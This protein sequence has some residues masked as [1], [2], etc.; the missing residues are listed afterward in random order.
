MLAG[1]THVF[2]SLSEP[3]E[4]GVSGVFEPKPVGDTLGLVF[5]VFQNLWPSPDHFSKSYPQVMVI[6][7]GVEW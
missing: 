6:T 7:D 1:E 4:S 5:Q 3:A 2:F